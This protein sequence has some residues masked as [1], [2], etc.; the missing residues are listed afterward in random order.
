MW[1]AQSSCASRIF[2]HI[3]SGALTV[4]Y[5][6]DIAVLMLGI[7]HYSAITSSTAFELGVLAGRGAYA[8]ASIHFA[9]SLS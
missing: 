5:E 2:V 9:T 1:P 8:A 4:K 3:L 7:R 6:V